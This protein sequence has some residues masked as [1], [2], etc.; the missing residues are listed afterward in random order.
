MCQEDEFRCNDGSCI[1]KWRQ[2]DGA[3]DCTDN[4][5]ESNCCEYSLLALDKMGMRKTQMKSTN[6]YAAP[7]NQ[8]C[9]AHN[10]INVIV[11]VVDIFCSNFYCY[12]LFSTLNNCWW[13]VRSSRAWLAC[14]LW[15]IR[16]ANG[17]TVPVL[18]VDRC[19]LQLRQ[20]DMDRFYSIFTFT[21]G[22]SSSLAS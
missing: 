3:P 9:S 14:T 11:V 4:E 22:L 16:M 10:A 17:V 15:G 8:V 7:W 13:T 20:M 5:D 1:P 18:F 21:L 6:I 12:F 2:C 19:A